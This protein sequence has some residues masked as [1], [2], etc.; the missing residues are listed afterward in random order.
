[1]TRYR[2]LQESLLDRPRRW[3]VTGVA[4]FIG[5]HLLEQ[6]LRLEQEV[7]GLDNF[8]TGY[9]HN[10]DDVARRV[11]AR[12]F[13][14]FRL[15]TGDI[16]DLATCQEAMQGVELVLHEAAL[17]S[18]PRSMV[19]PLAS[20]QTNVDGFVNVLLAAH[21]AGIERVV[22]AS[23][24]SVYGDE[25]SSP[26][27]EAR[28]GR[29]LSPYAATKMIDELYADTLGRTHGIDAVGLRYFNV[30]G[31]RQDPH[32]AYAAVIPRWT[33]LLISGQACSVFGDGSASRDFCFVDNVVQANLL[34]ALAPSSALEERVFNVACGHSTTLTEL[35]TIIRRQVAAE[36]DETALSALRREPPRAGDIQ[37]SLAS[38][39]RAQRALGY[40]PAVDVQTGL[41]RTVR[42]FLERAARP[43]SSGLAPISTQPA[44]EAS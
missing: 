17:G 8:A 1:M 29:L 22:Y 13:Q 24:S 40:E 21:E 28:R 9:Q 16:R 44:R 6:L 15:I 42:W 38:I 34:A 35:F 11:G 32:G 14:N 30:F 25:A 33:E 41:E 7:V 18:V 2:D 10:L 43:E 37:H 3:L 19:E 4:G 23:S 26:K 36:L 27:V 39:A 31:P 12:T 5:S 20:H